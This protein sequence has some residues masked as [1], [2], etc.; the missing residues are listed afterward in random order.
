[1][2]A[3]HRALA[4][5]NIEQAVVVYSARLGASPVVVVPGGHAL[6]QAQAVNLSIRKTAECSGAMRHLGWEDTDA[7]EFTVEAD[8]NGIV[9]KKLAACHQ[10]QKINMI[11]PGANYQLSIIL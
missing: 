9:W 4:V 5:S 10:V 1:M 7:T 2:R 8:C 11:W 6:W 3:F